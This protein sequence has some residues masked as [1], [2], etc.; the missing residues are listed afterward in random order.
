M[1]LWEN[2]HAKLNKLFGSFFARFMGCSKVCSADIFAVKIASP[3][4][5]QAFLTVE[6]ENILI[7][8]RENF[9]DIR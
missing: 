2:E 8:F 9:S 5:V 4:K 7:S 3:Q 6:Y 1:D